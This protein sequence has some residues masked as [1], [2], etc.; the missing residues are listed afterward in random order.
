MRTVMLVSANADRDARLEIEA[1]ARPVPEFI[2]LER[3]YGVR[4][5]DWSRLKIE[6]G[7]SA[8]RS[9]R[10]AAAGL[11]AAAGADAI[12]SDGEH[13]GIPLGIALKA[14]GPTR[15]HVVLGHHL[16]SRS[17]P[18]MLR[19]LRHAGIT[20]VLVHSRAQLK[21]AIE[22]LGFT[23]SSAA[24][25]PYYADARFWRPQADRPESLIVSAGREHRDYATLA[26]AVKDLPLQTVIA[27]GSLFSPAAPCRL[28]AVMPANIS[29]GMRG[30]RALRA[31][32]AQA[33]VVVV[34]LIPSDFQAGVTTILE[35]MAM[36]KPV[37]VTATDGQR[38][39]VIDGETGVLVPA[40]DAPALKAELQRLLAHPADRRRLGANAR[41]AVLAR[42]DLPIYAAALYRHLVDVARADRQAA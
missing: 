26:A 35:A 30:P 9:L 15:P 31:L 40:G 32:Y 42:F 18:W 12:F 19:W 2:A 23:P 38:D 5:L 28:P 10:H 36:A 8:S 41:E 7:R 37:V 16:T 11:R 14:I 13:V 29:V 24:F 6:P 25:V 1:G 34:P 22:A 17:K 39:I 20:R 3:D 33:E 27:A 21:I 4:L